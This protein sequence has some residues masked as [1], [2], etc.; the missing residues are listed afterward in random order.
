MRTKDVTH[1]SSEFFEASADG[2]IRGPSS[3][4]F[5]SCCTAS[6]ATAGSRGEEAEK[7]ATVGRFG[8]PQRLAFTSAAHEEANE[9]AR[10]RVLRLLERR[11][12]EPQRRALPL[13]GALVLVDDEDVA[14][15]GAQPPLRETGVEELR[16]RPGSAKER[17]PLSD[18]R[19]ACDAHDDVKERLWEGA[20]E[21]DG[22]RKA[23][24]AR[25]ARVEYGEKEP[26]ERVVEV[27]LPARNAREL[28]S[29]RLFP[30]PQQVPQ[31]A[32]Q[33]WDRRERRLEARQAV[34]PRGAKAEPLLHADDGASERGEPDRVR[35]SVEHARIV[36]LL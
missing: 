28:Q 8:A 16:W 17:L 34:A 15:G 26:F 30:A 22:A 13:C 29:L 31:E 23:L 18:V 12:Q 4:S 25:L 19:L 33:H 2:T 27:R 10:E 32:R 5:S 3:R 21:A 9:L 6:T 35:V 20:H 36:E 11:L 1:G 7:Q 14:R 24:A